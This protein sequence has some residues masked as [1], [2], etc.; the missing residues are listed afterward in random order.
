MDFLHSFLKTNHPTKA[1]KKILISLLSILT[2][3]CTLTYLSHRNSQRVIS[4]S[5]EVERSQEMK[6]HIAEV[7]ALCTD[8]ET[9]A[10]G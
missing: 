6:Y 10:R 7:V 5:E 1:E 3:L 8:L 9:G 2:I 4:S